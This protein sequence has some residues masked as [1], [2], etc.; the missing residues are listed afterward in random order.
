MTHTKTVAQSS[1]NWFTSLDMILA[2]GTSHTSDTA[3]KSPK[4]DILSEPVCVVSV[5]NQHNMHATGHLWLIFSDL[6]PGHRR[7]PGGWD[8]PSCR[9]PCTLWLLPQSEGLQLQLL[10]KQKKNK[11]KTEKGIFLAL[12]LKLSNSEFQLQIPCLLKVTTLVLLKSHLQGW[13]V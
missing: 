11:N 13:H 7:S 4:D 5:R 10:Q 1:L 6:L 12:Y 3:M 8:P 9:A 2:V